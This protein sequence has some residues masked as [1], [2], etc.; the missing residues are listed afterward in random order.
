MEIEN[1]VNMARKELANRFDFKGANAEIHLDHNDIKLS[2]DDEYKVQALG[3][4]VIAK[5]AKRGVDLKSV[6]KR[7]PE[8]SPLGHARQ[9]FHIQ[10]GIAHDVAKQ[11]TARIRELKLKVTAQTQDQQVRVQGKSRDDLQKVMAAVKAADLS[12]AVQF[13]NLRN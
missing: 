13:K 1:A 9:T 8:I 12:V 10:Q 2:A 6:D 4:I 3:E 7:D 5:L 11:I